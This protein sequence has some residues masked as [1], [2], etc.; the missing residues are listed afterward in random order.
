VC[1]DVKRVVDVLTADGGEHGWGTTL[2]A[3]PKDNPYI[4]VG[5]V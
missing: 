1:L 4:S 3:P 5:P 2:P